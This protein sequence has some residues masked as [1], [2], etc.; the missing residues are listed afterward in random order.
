MKGRV[1]ALKVRRGSLVEKKNV[2][3]QWWRNCGKFWWIET[4]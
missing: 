1:V 2:V 4:V 3:Q